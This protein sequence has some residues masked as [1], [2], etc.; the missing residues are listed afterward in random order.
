MGKHHAIDNLIEIFFKWNDEAHMAF[1]ELKRVI[2]TT[3]I[4]RLPDFSW[5]L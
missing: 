5:E 3:P 2:I 4:F 1:E